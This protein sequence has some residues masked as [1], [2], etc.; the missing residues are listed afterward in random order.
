MRANTPNTF[1]RQGQIELSAG[2]WTILCANGDSRRSPIEEAF[3]SAGYF[4][5]T[6][7]VDFVC[8]EVRYDPVPTHL[9]VANPASSSI[10]R[11]TFLATAPAIQSDQGD[12]SGG[13]V[14]PTRLMSQA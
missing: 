6:Y 3:L 11:K 12:L 8:G 14:S 4:S 2:N 1:T 10:A 7:Q 13:G 9:A 5:A